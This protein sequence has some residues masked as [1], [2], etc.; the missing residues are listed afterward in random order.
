MRNFSGEPV[1]VVGVAR[2]GGFVKN[3]GLSLLW[4]LVLS[5][6]AL[7]MSPAGPDGFCAKY[8]ASPLCTGGVLQPSCNLCHLNAPTRNA[9]GD[10]IHANLAPTAPRPLSLGDFATALPSALAAIE[11]ADADGDGYSNLVEIQRGTLPGDATSHPVDTACSGTNNPQYKVCQ[12]DAR[13]AYRKVLLDFCGQ[14]PSYADLQAFDARPDEASRRAFLDSELDRC[15]QTEFWRGKD[16]QVWKLAHPKIRPVQ[17][18]KSGAGPGPV[19]LADYDND[20]NLFVSTQLDNADARDVIK[21]KYYVQRSASAPTTYTQVNTMSGQFVDQAHRAGNMTSAWS[22][23]YFVMFTP[24]PRNLASQMYRAYL[25]L[26]IAKQEGLFS[27]SNEPQDYDNKGVGAQACAACHATLDPLTYPFR[28]YNGLSGGNQARNRY[29][30]NRLE[31]LYTDAQAAAPR[32]TQVPENGRIFN[33]PVADLQGW[34]TVAA[35][36]DAFA[37]ATVTDYWRL[38][39]GHR[40]TA[41]ENAEFV[42]TW[43]AFKGARGYHVSQMLHDLIH[44]EAYGA[45]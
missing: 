17:S 34:A 22:L 36:S 11:S 25:G 4:A 12:Y 27:V 15:L 45:P 2:D 42:A 32:L 39:M 40:P 19:P 14:A 24:V 43:Q 21:A 5:S 38:L 6:P 44:T 30:S 20:Y 16:G 23:M 13:Y 3:A 41:E 1:L 35:N 31:T 7:A 8:A 37:S 28:N 29:V 26:D 10:A 33:Q 18:L 9:F